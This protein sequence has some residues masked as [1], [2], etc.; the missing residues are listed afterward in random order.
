MNAG[1]RKELERARGMLIDAMEILTACSEEE[2]EYA[3]NMPENLQGSEKHENAEQI[4]GDLADS[5]GEIE[6]IVSVL[7]DAIEPK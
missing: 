3:D 2:Q 6:N 1:R 7:D 5:A 4:S